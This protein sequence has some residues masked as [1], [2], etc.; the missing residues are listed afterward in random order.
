MRQKTSQILYAYWNEVRRGRLAP[1]RFDIEPARISGILAETMILERIDSKTYRFRLAGTRICEQFGAE[2]RGSNFLALWNSDDRIR[3]AK[4]LQQ[5]ADQGGVAVL[6]FEGK[7]REGLTAK[8]E[9]ILLPLYHAQSTVDRF[10]GAIS[11]CRA[12]IWLGHEPITELTLEREEIVWPDGRP[13]VLVDK[14]DRQSPFL[15]AEHRGRIVRIEQRSFR[16]FDGGRTGPK[17]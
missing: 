17:Y 3:L 15:P 5:L 7:A 1:C 16:V 6:E 8:F 14:L 12:P 13:H 2:F 9:A 11:C 4:K 10:L